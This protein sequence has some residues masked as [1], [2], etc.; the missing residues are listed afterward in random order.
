MNDYGKLR[1]EFSERQST[2]NYLDITITIDNKGNINTRLYEKPDNLYLYLPANS[3]HPFSTLKG[4]IHGMVY[5]TLRLTST[6]DAQQEEL[7]N[8]VRRLT[9]RGYQQAMLVN[10]INT[11]Y[12]RINND[13]NNALTPLLR[14]PNN[15]V[16]FF[17]AYFHPQDPKSFQIQQLFEAEMLSPRKM[18]KKLP[19]LLNH[20]KA[21]LGVDKLII[22]YHRMPNLGNILSSRIIKSEDGPQV[23]SYL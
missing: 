5:R 9:A 8:L 2:V 13:T 20:R 7:Q 19:D 10:I 18:Y 4:L 6:K 17:H 14:H 1:W 3:A 16:C 11:T 22:A 23:S 15:K 12:H 21:R